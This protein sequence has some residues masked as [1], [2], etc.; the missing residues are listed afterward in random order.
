MADHDPRIEQLAG[1]L[2]CNNTSLAGPLEGPARL[3]LCIV[4]IDPGLAG[5]VAFYFP[6]AG[7][8]TVSD[9]P[10]AGGDVDAATLTQRFA[11]FRPD[12]AAVELVASQPG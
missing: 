6:S 3:A 5:A 11:Q 1:R 4:A 12:L 9:M 7:A 10:V 2:D 8:L